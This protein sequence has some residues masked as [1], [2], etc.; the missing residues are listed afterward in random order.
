MNCSYLLGK[1]MKDITQSYYIKQKYRKTDIHLLGG[2]GIINVNRYYTM[3]EVSKHTSANDGWIII[4]K[5]GVK[6]VFNVTEWIPNHPGG[7]QILKDHLGKDATDDFEAIGHSQV[8]YDTLLP[9]Y[10]IGFLKE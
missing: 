9:K 8:V 6:C 4:S 3:E 5:D 1:T 7:S 2:N 10:F